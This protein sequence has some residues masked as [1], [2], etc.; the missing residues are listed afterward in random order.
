[1]V[2]VL[3]ALAHPELLEA[4][5]DVIADA[6]VYADPMVLRGVL[7]QL[8]GDSELKTIELKT[9]QSGFFQVA[10]VAR[11]EDIDLLREKAVAFLIRYRDRGEDA[12]APGTEER[13]ET[14]MSLAVGQEVPPA[15]ME[16]WLAELGLD[17][18]AR[19]LKWSAPPSTHRLEAFS[20]TVI[21]AGMGG[22]NAAIQL[23]RAGIP[24]T[25][26]EKNDG[27]GGTWYENRYPGARVDTPSRSYTHIFGVDFPYP[28]SFCPWTENQ[29]YLDWVADT[30]E[31]RDDVVFN[32]E[33]RSLTWD[34]DSAMWEIVA[35]G[36][37]GRTLLRSNAVIT[38][39]GFLNRPNVPEVEGLDEFEGEWWHTARWPDGVDLT[40]KR[41]A[42]V[43]TGCTG[44]QMIPEL[45]LEAAHVTVFQRTP[46]WIFESP[47]YTAPLPPQVNWLDRN[48]PLHTN[49]MRFRICFRH[50]SS[51]KG[52]DIADIDPNFND[53]YSVSAGNKVVRDACIA[54]LQ[55]KL[56]DPELV[57]K[58][59]PPHPVFSAR[60]VLVDP[61]YSILDAIQRDN[62]TLVSS[63]LRRVVSTGVEADDGSQYDVDVIVFAT[64][65]HATE[66]LFPMSVRGRGGLTTEKLW[67]KD[68]PR[69]YLGCMVPEFPNMWLIYGPNTN[70]GLLVASFHEMTMQYALKCMEKLILDD[71]RTIEVK[72]EA[73]WRYGR[74]IDERNA[75]RAY[76]DP[77]TT[78]YYWSKYGRSVTS[79]GISGGEMWTFL[80]KPN[81]DDLEVH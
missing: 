3:T 35:D 60:P 16:L 1:M 15:Q 6:V 76:A 50:A 51:A 79:C 46:Q 48:L 8:T 29:K 10:A 73:Y 71:M 44:Y 64:G 4:T 13:L 14:S 49:F 22:L 26:L 21:G 58:M 27:V 39:V 7:Y 40:G 24:F 70:G 75:R 37:D 41:V 33:V 18:W 77:R 56:G 55:R 23:K 52:S 54:A 67:E 78:S 42:V 19:S 45:A 11:D 59:T 25:V 38:A 2:D 47:G 5:D 57:A 65:F 63:G 80:S 31:V 53:P 74:L 32:T 9:V 36:P 17:P 81:D 43:G 12:I 62:V 34:E 28:Y 68:G 20:V 72:E 69:A 61:E 66:Y 30:F